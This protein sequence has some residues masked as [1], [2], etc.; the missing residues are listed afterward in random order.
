MLAAS[1]FGC[2][3]D[4][5]VDRGARPDRARRYAEWETRVRAALAT[6]TCAYQPLAAFLRTVDQ[7]QVPAQWVAQCLDGWRED[8]HFRGLES[9]AD[10]QS[11]VDRVVVP[12]M[13]LVLGIHGG[14]RNE[15]FT[16]ALRRYTESYHRVDTLADMAE[17]LRDGRVHLPAQDLRRVGVSTEELLAGRRPPRLLELLREWTDLARTGLRRARD[18]CDAAPDELRPIIGASITVNELRLDSLEKAG[19]GILSRCVLPPVV[20]ALRLVLAERRGS[21][22]G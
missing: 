11:Y 2:A 15:P 14:T 22:H 8:L 19:L 9:E 6:G 13:R 7:C 5:I 12:P 10:F 18:L 1:W 21:W 16:V 20:P 4:D 3:T 17:D